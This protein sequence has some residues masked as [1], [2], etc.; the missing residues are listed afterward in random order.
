MAYGEE[1]AR[2]KKNEEWPHRSVREKNEIRS[3]NH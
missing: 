3:S 2:K 1:S